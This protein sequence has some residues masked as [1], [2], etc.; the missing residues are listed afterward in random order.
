MVVIESIEK[1]ILWLFELVLNYIRTLLV[2]QGYLRLTLPSWQSSCLNLPRVGVIV[3]ITHYS[4]GYSHVPLLYLYTVYM[5][6]VEDTTSLCFK[7]SHWQVE[8]HCVLSKGIWCMLVHPLPFYAKDRNQ[9]L[10]HVRQ[11]LYKWAIFQPI[12]Q[13]L[14]IGTG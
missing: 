14:N 11:V 13:F 8:A 1:K 3:T 5:G 7:V 2:L 10:K 4:R 6:D 12:D 9:D